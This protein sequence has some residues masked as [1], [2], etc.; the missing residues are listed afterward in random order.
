MICLYDDLYR[1]RDV[2]MVVVVTIVC[3]CLVIYSYD[4]LYRTRDVCLV[5]VVTTTLISL[6][7]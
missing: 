2:C 3:T 5:E 1:V 4:D 6:L 7:S